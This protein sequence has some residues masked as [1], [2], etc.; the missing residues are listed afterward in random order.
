MK[1]LWIIILVVVA[2]VLF[3]WFSQRTGEELVQSPQ[4][5]PTPTQPSVSLTPTPL[6]PFPSP[7]KTASP[8]PTKTPTVK[9]VVINITESSFTPSEITINAGD[10]V[11]FR[12]ERN[13]L[14]WPASAVHPTHELYPGSGIQKC[15][16][17]GPMAIFDACRGLQKG[18][19]FSFT[20]NVK[21]AWPFHDH[22]APSLKGKIIVQ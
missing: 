11:L 14:S 20:F 9:T 7:T 8:T 1:V 22:L 10:T 13:Q 3:F 6:S 19:S 2:A 21:G 18:E 17:L 16:S 15:G 5:T 12:N 4:P